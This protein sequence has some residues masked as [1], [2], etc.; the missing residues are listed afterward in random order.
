M[1]KMNF[2]RS[3]VKVE[4]ICINITMKTEEDLDKFAQEI[5]TIKKDGLVWYSDYKKIDNKNIKVK[6][7]LTSTKNITIDIIEQIKGLVPNIDSI[8][9][10]QYE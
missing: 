4:L 10:S 9:I 3:A 8:E 1:S 2:V 5:F 7:S 6:F